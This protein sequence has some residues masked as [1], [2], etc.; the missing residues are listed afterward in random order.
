MNKQAFLDINKTTVGRAALGG[1]VAGGSAMALLNLFRR[2]KEM[3][4]ERKAL[5][6]EPE[7]DEDTIVI[8]L[9]PKASE[10]TCTKPTK[11]T[12]V[13]TTRRGEASGNGK[14]FRRVMDGT[15]G[16]KTASGWPTL[17]AATLAGGA[18]IGIGAHLVNKIY[19]KRRLKALKDELEAAQE[20]YMSSLQGS[21]MAVDSL[22]AVPMSKGAQH[23]ESKAFGFLDY[24]VSMAALLALLGTGGSAYITKKV[25]DQQFADAESKGLDKPKLKRIVF[26]TQPGAKM[27]GHEPGTQED[28]DCVTAALGVMLDKV[29]ERTV[30]LDKPYVKSAMEKAGTTAGT[31]IKMAQNTDSL[32]EYMRGNPEL[33]KMIQNAY[34]EQHP[35]YNKFKFLTKLPGA[36]RFMDNKLYAALQR[37]PGTQAPEVAKQAAPTSLSGMML[38]SVVGQRIGDKDS[39][40]EEIAAAV[41]K[42][43]EAKEQASKK[44]KVTPEEQADGVQLAA[45]DPEAAAYLEANRE[46][47]RAILKHMAAT[48]KI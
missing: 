18:G 11:V 27:A 17:T 48:G 33:R 1:A 25:L 38:S 42:A 47:V 5:L 43:Q 13:E 31:L 45:D 15:F 21:K 19:E 20:E 9:P 30:I 16:T 39:N 46:R 7:T 26:Q 28:I 24:P 22:F 35:K 32:I 2:A 29:G 10:C 23:S 41:I 12:A 34:I 40:P 8:R 36:G 4:D 14:Q 37:L 3:S 6:H 44:P